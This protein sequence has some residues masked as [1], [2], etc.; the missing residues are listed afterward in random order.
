MTATLLSRSERQGQL[1]LLAL[2]LGSGIAILDGSIVNIA[3]R[4]IGSELDASMAEL[5]WVTNGYLLSLASLVLVGG[6][7]GDRSG[8][9]RI[10]LIGMSVFLIASALCALAQSPSQLIAVRV[11]QG[12]GG[13]LLTP[14]A[15][16]IIQSSFRVEDRAP[17][18][19]TWAGLSGV[20]AAVGPFLG[21]WLVDHG[22]WRWIFGI[23]IPLCLAVIALT[24]YAVPESRDPEATGR[25]DWAGAMLT[26][27]CL[28]ASTYALTAAGAGMYRT[29]WLAGVA[30]L[31]A[32][33]GWIWSA[34][35]TAH[36]LVPLALFSSRVFSAANAMTALVYGALGAVFFVV[37]LQ[38]QVTSGWSALT[39]G[40][41]A[42]PVTVA[43]MLLSSRA[44]AIADR[45]GPR[46]PMSVGPLL[47]AA[48]V[49][50]LLGVGAGTRWWGVLP[51]I[52]VFALGLA[53]LV[54]PLTAA[55]LRAAP[56]Q[57]TGVASGVNNAVARAGSLL[58]VAAVPALAGLSGDAY[59]DPTA[60]TH[61]YRTAMIG[62]AILLASGGLVSWFGL[63][64][65]RVPMPVADS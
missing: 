36:P 20:A 29:A 53:T 3:L 27:G 31:L 46:L 10:Y 47:C 65:E 6:A 8:R 55:V 32:G 40:V 41:S 58:A 34:R 18:I 4:T 50:L 61:G 54:S 39:S 56:A 35:R 48:G 63:G 33:A 64:A 7:L 57:R 22:G 59:L 51:G 30:A 17:A 16:A 44:A 1:T 2:T 11:I 42:L 5:S 49:L 21:G 9:R 62:C 38:L 24:R 45:I 37:V 25:F 13:A 28:A 26:I 23:N 14:G 43:L 19:G 15:L 60:M 52:V 12:V